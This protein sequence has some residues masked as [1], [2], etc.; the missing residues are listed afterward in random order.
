MIVHDGYA[1]IYLPSQN[2]IEIYLPQT[3]ETMTNTLKTVS[4][5][6]VEVGDDELL[7]LL[8]MT[9]WIFRRRT[10]YENADGITSEHFR[11]GYEK[12]RRDG[13]AE[14]LTEIEKGKKNEVA[15]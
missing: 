9:E 11:I 4:D 6:E 5:R 10:E 7:S 13:Y 14:A 2:K 3:L 8:F 1:L 15:K 12:G